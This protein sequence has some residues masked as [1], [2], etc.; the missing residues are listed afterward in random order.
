MFIRYYHILLAI[1]HVQSILSSA[2]FIQSSLRFRECIKHVR[3]VGN[4]KLQ[5]FQ[6]PR[7]CE[8]HKDAGNTSRELLHVRSCCMQVTS[9]ANDTKTQTKRNTIL[10]ALILDRRRKLRLSRASKLS[11]S[12][13]YRDLDQAR[14]TR[15]SRTT[16]IYLTLRKS[17]RYGHYD[18][19]LSRCLPRI[20]VKSKL[21]NWI[22]RKS[23]I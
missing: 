8:T 19:V 7:D 11:P 16:C 17:S 5:T 14:L 18:N 13:H 15:H 20:V 4:F 3:K 6:F 12:E 23:S 1:C 2:V 21:S 22:R 9:R 10:P